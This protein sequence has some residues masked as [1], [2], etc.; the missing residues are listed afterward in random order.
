MCYT[1]IYFNELRKTTKYVRTVGVQARIQLYTSRIRAGGVAD[2]N[3]T[4]SSM[5]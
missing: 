3:N 5:Y 4:F 2:E 1:I